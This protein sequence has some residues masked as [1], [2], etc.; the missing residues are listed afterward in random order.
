MFFNFWYASVL[1][2]SL[3]Y[4]AFTSE[5]SF[6]YFSFYPNKQLSVLFIYRHL[7]T[8]YGSFAFY[9][10]VQ[11]NHKEQPSTVSPNVVRVYKIA[12]Y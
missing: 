5:V 4:V 1:P 7:I 10:K 11:F 2:K 6:F 9:F 12:I 8:V 3:G